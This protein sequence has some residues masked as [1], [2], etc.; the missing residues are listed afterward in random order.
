MTLELSGWF[1]RRKR[2]LTPFVFALRDLSLSFS[3]SS[4]R[5]KNGLCGIFGCGCVFVF[6]LTN[7][8]VEDKAAGRS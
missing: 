1:P 3:R 2:W 7:G 6:M 5:S 4:L 8:V